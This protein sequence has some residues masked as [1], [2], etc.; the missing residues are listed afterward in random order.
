MDRSQ[1][2][3]LIRE[4]EQSAQRVSQQTEYWMD[5]REQLVMEAEMH[6]KMIASLVF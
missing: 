4:I 6:N 3:S 2:T 5:S 1:V